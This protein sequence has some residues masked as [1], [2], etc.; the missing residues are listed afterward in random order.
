MPADPGHGRDLDVLRTSVDRLR[1]VV[2]RLVPGDL[3]R[4]SYADEWTTA[5]V[6]SH[7][8]SGA[9]IM[10]HQIDQAVAG[11]PADATFAEAVWA[12]WNAK[13]AHQQASD[14]LDADTA[15]IE[16]LDTITDAERDRFQLT[17]G[18][19]QLDLVGVIRMRLNEHVV[20]RWDIAITFEP[21]AT[22][23]PDAVPIMVDNLDIVARFGAKPD[24]THASFDIATTEPDRR[25]Q[26]ELAGDTTTLTPGPGSGSSPDLVLPA[27]AFIRLVYGRLD[28]ARTPTDVT[29]VTDGSLT[30]LRNIYRGI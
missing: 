11:Q 21:D 4:M 7:L 24:S 9:V 12:D 27:E 15:L 30:K 28:P 26:L 16:R 5:Q 13:P 22:L 3:D 14:A 2:E 19:F 23:D 1:A 6:L 20:H 10:R 18:P 8:G 29:T 25:F 17:L